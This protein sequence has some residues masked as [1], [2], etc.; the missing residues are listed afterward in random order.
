MKDYDAWN[1]EKKFLQQADRE[2]PVFHERQIWWCSIG[3]NLGDEQDGKN[4]LFE[5]P[6]LVVKKFNDRIAWIVPFTSK[7]K[8]GVYY[9][10]LDYQGNISTAILSQLRL[11][12][13]K[14]FRRLIRRITPNQLLIIQHK[15]MNL[16]K[17][18]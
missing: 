5:R 8:A 6:V 4:E 7:P 10:S 9:H 1:H 15:I 18:Q 12:S 17:R 14:R 2:A 3:Y 16:L 11:V 13:A